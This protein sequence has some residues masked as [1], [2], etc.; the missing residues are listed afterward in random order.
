MT[1]TAGL[2]LHGRRIARVRGCLGKLILLSLVWI[3]GNSGRFL[4]EIDINGTHARHLL[5]RLLD[6]DST[7][8]VRHILHVEHDDF[9]VAARATMGKAMSTAI[10]NLRMEISF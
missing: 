5:Q 10:S 8:F 6:T 9:G 4:V 1:F 7:E 2:L 3:I